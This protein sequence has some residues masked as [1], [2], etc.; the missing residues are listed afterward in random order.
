MHVRRD[1]YSITTTIFTLNSFSKK[2]N[3]KLIV[4]WVLGSIEIMTNLSFC[5]L[6]ELS[7]S[8]F[9]LVHWLFGLNRAKMGPMTIRFEF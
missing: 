4:W 3:S 9:I 8:S 5:F 7:F 6:V 2:I 1:K